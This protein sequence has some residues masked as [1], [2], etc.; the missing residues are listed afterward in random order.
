MDN[1]TP[2]KSNWFFGGLEEVLPDKTW[3]RIHRYSFYLCVVMC[4]AVVVIKAYMQYSLGQQLM[5]R[6]RANGWQTLTAFT[7]SKDVDEPA[8]WEVLS[9]AEP[10]ALATEVDSAGFAVTKLSELPDAESVTVRSPAGEARPARIAGQDRA[11]DLALLRVSGWSGELSYRVPADS[12]ALGDWVLSPGQENRDWLGV[13][14]A[15]TREIKAK[16][17]LGVLMHNYPS[18]NGAKITQIVPDS[19]A[20]HGGLLAGDTVIGINERRI[21]NAGQLVDYINECHPE[22][23]IVLN[24][25]RD[26]ERLSI[27]IQL[28]FDTIFQ[29][30]LSE[31]FTG[32]ASERQNGFTRVI[33]H[34]VPLAPSA[35][36]GPLFNAQG[37]IVGVNIARVDRVTTYALPWYLVEASV[38]RMKLD[39]I[40]AP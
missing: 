5:E 12:V 36:G 29:R 26:N 3:A 25:F 24:V 31:R 22:E 10:V 15:V 17:A 20:F 39:S 27:P 34:T 35:M 8:I 40:E 2:G 19:P 28:G 37:E 21:K 4:L 33:Q 30:R 6:Y 23:Q 38:A 7:S 9:G 14:S 13:V 32:G 16:A 11:L 1:L 18:F